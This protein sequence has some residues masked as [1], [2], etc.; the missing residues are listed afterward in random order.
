MRQWTGREV[1]PFWCRGSALYVGFLLNYCKLELFLAII[2]K[3]MIVFMEN[4]LCIIQ[5]SRAF[6]VSPSPSLFP[7][8]SWNRDLNL[9][10]NFLA[11]PN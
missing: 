11:P 9:S 6:I 1:S 10:T 3:E 7:R 5:L 2:A 8:R 4:K